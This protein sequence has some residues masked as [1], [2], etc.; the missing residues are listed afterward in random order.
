MEDS[1]IEFIQNKNKSHELLNLETFEAIKLSNYYINE[2][3]ELKSEK[4]IPNIFSKNG[5]KCNKKI[6]CIQAIEE[7]KSL[8]ISE[9]SSI[10]LTEANESKYKEGI[11]EK[12]AN[13]LEPLIKN[14]K[15][16]PIIEENDELIV[17]IVDDDAFNIHS[18]EMLLYSLKIRY[19]SV[20]NGKDAIDKI[21]NNPHIKFVFMD[22]NMPVMDGWEATKILKEKMKNCE[23][24]NIPIVANTAYSDEENRKKCIQAGMNEIVSKPITKAKIIQILTSYNLM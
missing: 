22:C 19:E 18:L 14:N 16:L 17:L 2:I 15:K 20:Y 11:L 4:N 8:I 10:Y 24:Q 5:F 13:P 7:P 3:N 1:N 21:M 9:H 6:S 12:S 23:I